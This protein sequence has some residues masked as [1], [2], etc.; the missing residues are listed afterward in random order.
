[1]AEDD[2]PQELPLT[3][4]S[5]KEAHAIIKRYIHRTPLLTSKILNKIIGTPI[6]SDKKK[7][8]K[9]NV[10]LKCENFQKIGAFK[11]RGAHHALIRLI[12]KL[13]IDEVKKRG[14]VTHSS[15]K[16]EKRKRKQAQKRERIDMC[17]YVRIFADRNYLLRTFS[18][19]LS[20][21]QSCSSISVGSSYFRR[22]FIYS[23]AYDIHT[24]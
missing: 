22:T 6:S 21:R 8:P 1:M 2:T 11:A 9:V 10:Y 12:D 23:D 3:P 20:C 17:V 15:G 18:H 5:I 24:Q 13:G 19:I 4:E 16:K 7:A 14:V